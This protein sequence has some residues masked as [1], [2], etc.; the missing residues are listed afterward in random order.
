MGSLMELRYRM[1]ADTLTS[2]TTSGSVVNFITN[3]TKK[4]IINVSGN[5]SNTTVTRTGANML[6][7]NITITSGYYNDSGILQSSTG[8]GH[9]D[10]IPVLPN[11]NYTVYLRYSRSMTSGRSGIY[12][13]TANKQFIKRT[14]NP[15]TSPG[16]LFNFT[17]DATCHFISFQVPLPTTYSG[18][19]V[20]EQSKLVHG[21]SGSGEEPYIGGTYSLTQNIQALLGE[22]N[23]WSNGGTV[24]V[25]YWT[26]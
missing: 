16:L 4:L 2:Y 22:N 25:K 15:I 5:S 21:T 19:L 18:L 13:W 8:T 9:T 11:H 23:V 10:L 20:L 14:T 24:S 1:I 3:T 26:H 17:T 7:P 6:S 12:F